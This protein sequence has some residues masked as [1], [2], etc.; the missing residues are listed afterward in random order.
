MNEFK[1]L[2]ANRFILR[3][4]SRGER[5]NLN[6]EKSRINPSQFTT[7][8][9]VTDA[10]FYRRG[11]GSGYPPCHPVPTSSC[12]QLGQDAAMVVPVHWAWQAGNPIISAQ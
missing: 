4:K 1:K 6:L 3:L 8:E 12:Q 2:S 11:S 10:P 9:G 5:D 7:E